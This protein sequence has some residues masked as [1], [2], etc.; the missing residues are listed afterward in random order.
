M[1]QSFQRERVEFLSQDLLLIKVDLICYVIEAVTKR[2]TRNTTVRFEFGGHSLSERI[3]EFVILKGPSSPSG[4]L[5]NYCHA[6]ASFL[7]Y[8]QISSY[9]TLNS[10]SFAGYLEWMK[11]NKSAR[12]LNSRC[13]GTRRV[14]GSFILQFME[15]LV[16]VGD[17]KPNQ[18]FAARLR[19]QQ[20]FRGINARALE[21]MRLYAI[22]PEDYVCLIRAI[23]M[24]YEQCKDVLEQSKDAQNRYDITFPLLPFS[25]LLGAKLAVRAVEFNN[26]KVRDLRGDRLLLNPPNKKSSEIGLPLSVMSALELAQKWMLRYRKDPEPDDPLLVCPCNMVQGILVLCSLIPRS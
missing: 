24:E 12:T 19:Q 22:S 8:S 9:Q 4:T 23:R 1:N 25:M 14:Y 7:E 26:L 3:C 21:H 17:I 11:T 18:A 2:A 16:D 10:E 13:E 6:L 15:W 5:A 20:A